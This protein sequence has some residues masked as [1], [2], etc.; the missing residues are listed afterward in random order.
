RSDAALLQQRGFKRAH[1]ALL[2]LLK[3]EHPER[4]S[5]RLRTVA[6]ETAAHYR[7]PSASFVKLDCNMTPVRPAA[8]PSMTS[9]LTESAMVGWGPMTRTL[10]P[11]DRV[12]EVPDVPVSLLAAFTVE[13]SGSGSLTVSRPTSC[14]LTSVASTSPF[15]TGDATV[16]IRW[17]V[18]PF[19]SPL[20]MKR[21]R[22]PFGTLRRTI[23]GS[24]SER[25]STFLA[26]TTNSTSSLDVFQML[27]AV[28]KLADGTPGDLTLTGMVLN[29]PFAS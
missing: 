25:M 3:G 29:L 26:L 11:F 18:V 28:R 15:A 10:V 24:A 27:A 7:V 16:S 13:T 23:D 17:N 5:R 8:A 6:V 4:R 12:G 22:V 21:R 14:W 20:A 2:D 19:R 1:L 9:T